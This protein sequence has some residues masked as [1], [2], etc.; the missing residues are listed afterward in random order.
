MASS[1]LDYSIALTTFLAT[2]VDDA[3]FASIVQ[4]LKKDEPGKIAKASEIPL[5]GGQLWSN[6]VDD[7]F[8]E[9]YRIHQ[10]AKLYTTDTT[11]ATPVDIATIDTLTT[12]GD[13]AYM[14]ATVTARDGA[15][16]GNLVEVQLGGTFFRDS[17]T[18]SVM[19]PISTVARV[20]FT[21][22]TASLFVS[23][24]TISARVT[25]EAATNIDW[26]FTVNESRR[27]R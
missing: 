17:G 2:T 24:D 19:N 20:G 15:N 11:T 12:N 3:T 1:T 23:G 8:L 14:R 22:A 5:A 10:G 16:P 4:V 13:A 9:L 21:T 6:L 18:V 7:A 26:V 27:L 25:G